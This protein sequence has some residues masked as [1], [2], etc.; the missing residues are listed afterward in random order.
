MNNANCFVAIK[1]LERIVGG[2]CEETCRNGVESSDYII[3]DCISD[4]DCPN[5]PTLIFT[6]SSQLKSR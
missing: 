2:Q 1:N 6:S 5:D 4:G 3:K